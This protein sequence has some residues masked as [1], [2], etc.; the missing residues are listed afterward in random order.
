MSELGAWVDKLNGLHVHELREL[1]Q[2]EGVRGVTGAATR[3]V[4]A[5]F[6]QAKIGHKVGVAQSGISYLEILRDERDSEDFVPSLELEMFIT[7]FDAD[8]YPELVEERKA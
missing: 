2:N 5:R 3:C 8:W 6:L 4:I 7:R 1:M